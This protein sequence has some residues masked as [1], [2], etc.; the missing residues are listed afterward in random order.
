M[1]TT[2]LPFLWFLLLLPVA[3][4]FETKSFGNPFDAS[5]KSEFEILGHATINNQAL[6]LTED[7]SNDDSFFVNNSGRIIYTTPY[8][9]W[10]WDDSFKSSN[11]SSSPRKVISFNSSFVFNIYPKHNNTVGEGLAFV[12]LPDSQ[13]MPENSHGGFLG[14][15]NSSLDGNPTNQF[16]AVE[17]DTFQ[18][19]YD[20]DNN[21]VGLNINSVRS[22]VTTSLGDLNINLAPL[23]GV[24]YRAWVD[25]SGPIHR[26]E[27]YLAIEKESK[28]DKPL[29]NAT[30]DLSAHL[31]KKSYF[32]F[33]GSTGLQFQLNCVLSWSLTVEILPEKK[34]FNWFLTVGVPLAGALL[35]AVAC[36][37]GVSVYRRRDKT[38]QRL[39]TRLRSLPGTPREFPYN[40]LKKATENFHGKN[41]LG[42]GGFG[43]VFKGVIP[44]E[45]DAVAVKRFLRD[46][47]Q[48]DFLSELT[49]INRLRHRNLVS[50]LGEL[51]YLYSYWVSPS[52]RS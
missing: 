23:P 34:P 44:G 35:L 51:Y 8:K 17:F 10:E 6:Q 2:C 13:S 5:S 48:E 41:Q 28:P 32:G 27:V 15:T 11:S 37:G 21:H 9:I 47:K 43:A 14:L 29:L 3:A 19:Y 30:I 1:T 18:Q 12:I 50:L 33:S 49:I 4:K 22:M 36:L 38:D 16:F 39:A 31:A 24:Q 25:Y 46:T 42:K 45:E 20:P 40:V 26:I 7:T 52:P